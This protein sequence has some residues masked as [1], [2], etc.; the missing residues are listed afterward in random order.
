MTPWTRVINSMTCHHFILQSFEKVLETIFL[1]MTLKLIDVFNF[2]VLI[3]R[4]NFDFQTWNPIKNFFA[5]LY[6]VLVWIQ[7]VVHIFIV[8]LNV[9]ASHG[10]STIGIALPLMINL[11]EQFSDAS[12]NQTVI[13]VRWLDCVFWDLRHYHLWVL[14][15]TS[16]LVA[17][18]GVCFAWSSLAIGKNCCVEAL[19]NLTYIKMNVKL[20]K[21]C[22]LT[23]LFSK[24]MIKIKSLMPFCYR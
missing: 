18:H 23:I 8:E 11:V 7:K 16:I 3:V 5:I 6:F 14:R 1:I 21:Q 22:L 13:A 15:M 4:P 2:N 9:L 17:L 19:D 20:L 12:R 24:N 10:Y